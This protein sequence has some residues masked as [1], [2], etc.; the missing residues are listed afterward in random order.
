MLD[1]DRKWHE[2][3]LRYGKTFG[4]FLLGM[5]FV[6]TTDHRI[7]DA[8]LASNE[9]LSKNFVYKMLTSWLGN[10]LLLSSGKS[11]QTM[12]KI[13][14]P[15]FHFKILEGFVE[16]FDRQSDA[17][18]AKLKSKADG[19]TPVNIYEPVGLLT[20]DIIAGTAVQLVCNSLTCF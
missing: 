19:I 2:F 12:R 14:T 10:G 18:I 8:L 15:T 13:I 17:L 20:L 9:N 7:V 4:S 6:V 16:V 3:I 5:V 11:W 1:Y